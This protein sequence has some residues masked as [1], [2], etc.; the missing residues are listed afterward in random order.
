FC[1]VG[2]GVVLHS[3]EGRLIN[4]EGDYEHP[5]SRGTLC[6]KGAGAIQLG[7]NSPTRVLNVLYR[8]PFSDHGEEK[9]W[10][11]T[12]EEI[13]QRIKKARDETFE[14]RNAKSQLVNRMQGFAFIGGAC[15]HNEE[16]YAFLKLMRA[17]GIVNIDNHA[18][19]CHSSTVPALSESFGRGAM[20]NHPIDFK[21]SDCLLVLGSNIAENHPVAFPWA[22]QAMRERGAPLI[23][24]D[25]RFNRTAAH[26]T[27]YA[28]NRP[29][30]DIA[31]L[32]GMVNYIFEHTRYHEEYVRWYTNAAYILDPEFAT[33][34]DLD[35]IFTGL[36]LKTLDGQ[37]LP[38]QSGKDVAEF[39]KA[40]LRYGYYDKKTWF[41]LTRERP[42][43][44][45]DYYRQLR[46]TAKVARV[47][48]TLR[49]P[50]C[51]F[52]RLRRQY[53][54][55]TPEKVSEITG[56][57]KDLLLRIYEIYTQTGA[58][59]K[60]GA[61]MYAMGQTQ[62]TKG[63]QNIRMLAIV[64]LLLGNIGKAGGGVNALRGH[65]NIQGST[66]NPV[67]FDLLPGYFK[68]P[69]ASQ[70]TLRD[71]LLAHTPVEIQPEDGVARPANSW[72][73]A[74]AYFVSLMKAF[75]GDAATRENEW[76]YRYLP[77]IEGDPQ[78]ASRIEDRYDHV[79]IFHKI[80]KGI[81]KGLW[82]MGINPAVG[83]PNAAFERKAMR[84]LDFLVVHDFH[85]SESA[86]IW[87][88][89][90]DPGVD[91]AKVKT[92]V[93]LLPAAGPFE[94]EGSKTHTGRWVQWFNAAVPPY[95]DSKDEVEVADLLYWKLRELYEKEGGAFPEPLL[96]LHWNF[97]G[98]GPYGRLP[99]RLEHASARAVAREINGYA[100][101]DM[102]LEDGTVIQT[103]QQVPGF[104]ALRADGSTAC[105][106][107]VYS[108]YYT[109]EGLIAA[110]RDN[111][112][113]T[114]LGLYP[115]WAFSWPANQRILYNRA[116]V[117]LSGKPWDPTRPV[118]WWDGRGWQGDVPDG[119]GPPGA[120]L[121]FVMH[122]EGV[123]HLFGYSIVKDAPFPEHYEPYESVV[124]NLLS[125]VQ[126]NP[127][128]W[129][130]DNVDP[131]AS[132]LALFDSPDVKDY[133]LV[134]ST[135]RLTEYLT[136]MSRN[137][138][139]LAQLQPQMFVE[140]S[141]EL[142]GELGIKD[143][144]IVAVVSKRGRVVCRALVTPRV[145]PLQVNGRTLHVVGMPWH[146]GYKGFITGDIAN[147]NTPDIGD[148]NTHIQASTAF[149]VRIEKATKDDMAR[150]EAILAAAEWPKKP[151]LGGI[152]RGERSIKE[153][154]A[155]GATF[156]AL[157][158]V[159]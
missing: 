5:I 119:G 79:S 152:G 47:D 117:D 100:L 38:V 82:L 129:R 3:K 74:P 110:R 159:K 150:H 77:K 158:E 22:Q 148:P 46:P 29:G 96:R 125:S 88:E 58:P 6:P 123:G 36:H 101:R 141:K 95:G 42:S 146:W 21:N 133:P 115:G 27:I 2:C 94:R 64:Q 149:L 136:S 76:A 63:V 28:Q 13:A 144:E 41:Y 103:G 151:R 61:M 139:W 44:G 78:Q 45:P 83:G 75:W 143:G 145:W 113:P 10:D 86:S 120:I 116:S 153:H 99:A 51:V 91:P 40:N 106:N 132:P 127:C 73:H 72:K 71:Y 59:D 8:A 23:V 128:V 108:G 52:Q 1:S 85:E 118:I 57:P 130:W 104:H 124:P 81:V 105:G 35:G 98:T 109:E 87:Q 97:S 20:T 111:R 9:D 80:D 70:E 39:N 62:H 11:W 93:F 157:P 31:F 14:E 60:A 92:E 56:V 33:A 15:N 84:N 154:E 30:T 126:N 66:D 134:C 137:V 69:V 32:G 107:W 18:R 90:S 19:I 131:E 26:A 17:L 12:I 68:T 114:G 34:S 122:A 155:G 53:A 50:H 43:E 65:S 37:D 147:N 55:Y 67:L 138:I 142:A 112:D 49:H 25:P 102:T 48:R 135:W 140:M 24:V 54:R 4:V 121:P 89:V 7:G 16:C 156:E